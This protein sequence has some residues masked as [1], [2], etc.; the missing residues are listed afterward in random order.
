MA[1]IVMLVGS[2]R[3]HGNTD[4]LAHAFLEGIDQKKNSIAVIS[5]PDIKV[6]GCVGCN[7]CYRDAE[8]RCALQDDMQ[9]IY[10]EL[11]AAEVLVVATPIYF[12]GI[13]SQLKAVIDR[14]H[15]PIRGTFRL[16][17]L[18]LLAVCADETQEV[19]D[20]V[21]A[22]YRSTLRYFSLKNARCLTVT[23][24]SEKGDIAGNPALEEARRLGVSL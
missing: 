12:Y 7:Y 20:S 23:G 8:H 21:K 16:K 18:V 9:Q 24:V 5:I 10:Q 6:K 22:M 15:N 19:F 13:P 17:K 2:P 11:S 4:T 3:K 1:K 14:L